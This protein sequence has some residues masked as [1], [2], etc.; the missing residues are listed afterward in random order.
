MVS[1]AD[2]IV[3]EADRRYDKLAANYLA[4]VKRFLPPG[5]ACASIGSHKCSSAERRESPTHSERK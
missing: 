3:P 5:N 4:F 2:L 1:G